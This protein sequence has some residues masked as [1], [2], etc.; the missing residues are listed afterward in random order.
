MENKKRAIL[1]GLAVFFIVAV[2]F[3]AGF[4][5]Y[6]NKMLRVAAGTARP[7]F[8]YT[9]HSIEELNKLY[10]QYPAENV[11]TTQTPEETYQKFRNYL[12]KNDI[13]SALS[14]IF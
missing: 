6:K 13:D 14:L 2:L 5:W 12:Q 10:P 1:M 3:L 8:P 11:A 4:V 9:D 7:N